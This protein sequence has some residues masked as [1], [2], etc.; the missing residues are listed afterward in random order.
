M[1]VLTEE[2]ALPILGRL[3]DAV[4]IPGFT[5]ILYDSNQFMRACFSSFSSVF[6]IYTQNFSI[7]TTGGAS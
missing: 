5:V 2:E 3:E 6:Q 1:Q 7:T 4:S